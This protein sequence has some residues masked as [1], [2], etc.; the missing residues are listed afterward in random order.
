MANKTKT[1]LSLC[2]L[3]SLFQLIKKK[4]KKSSQKQ[5]RNKGKTKDL[6]SLCPCVDPSLLI[7]N[8]QFDIVQNSDTDYRHMICLGLAP[9]H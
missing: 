6:E 7:Y 3:F 5:K 8:S 9:V 2:S 1:Q 4:K